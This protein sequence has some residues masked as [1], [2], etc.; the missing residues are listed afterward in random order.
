MLA[1]VNDSKMKKQNKTKHKPNNPSEEAS[2]LVVGC[3]C[4]QKTL[5]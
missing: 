5:W 2:I 4:T 3:V 1:S